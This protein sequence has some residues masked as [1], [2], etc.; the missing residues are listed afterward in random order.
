[1]IILKIIFF[2]LLYLILFLIG[3]ILVLI[4]SPIKGKLDLETGRINFRGSY[5]FGALKIYYRNKNDAYIRIF[6]FRIKIKSSS[7]STSEGDVI[8]HIIDQKN[9]ESTSKEIPNDYDN[10]NKDHS[11]EPVDNKSEKKK[12]NKEEKKKNKTSKKLGRPSLEV[13]IISAK[14]AKKLIKTIAPK[15]AEFELILGLG[16]PYYSGMSS[17][18]SQMIL[19]PLN[20][21]NGYNFRLIPDYHD[22]TIDYRGYFYVNFSIIRLIIPCLTYI[23]KKPIRR[24][25]QIFKRKP[26]KNDV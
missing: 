24:Y 4:V 18:I 25:F 6:G 17:I 16:D 19:I 12:K 2:F 1:M 3:L 23:L 11:D 21:F 20:Q 13:I 5:L 14:L 15:R 7:K 9:D 8:E 10:Q 26:K 22:V